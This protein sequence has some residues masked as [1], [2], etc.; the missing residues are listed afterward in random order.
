MKIG[1]DEIDILRSG[2]VTIH[3]RDKFHRPIVVLRPTVQPEGIEMTSEK[4]AN[5]C[6]FLMYYMKK[7][8]LVPG[9]IESHILIVDMAH[10]E[11]LAWAL[12]L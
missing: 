7:H 2:F 8:M 6:A 5:A 10:T 11:M 9:K 1:T 12:P 4:L 3:G